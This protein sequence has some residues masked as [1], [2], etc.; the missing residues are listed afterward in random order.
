MSDDE[1]DK[2]VRAAVFDQMLDD[3]SINADE[4]LL[5]GQQGKLVEQIRSA[6][7]ELDGSD[8]IV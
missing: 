4:K 3:F 1:D 6:Q 7:K 2:I 8:D 5:A